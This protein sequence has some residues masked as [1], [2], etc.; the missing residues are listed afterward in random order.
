MAEICET[1][2]FTKWKTVYH[3]F[4]SLSERGWFQ[5][6]LKIPVEGRRAS[7]GL[8]DAI[9]DVDGIFLEYVKSNLGTP[10]FIPIEGGWVVERTFSWMDNYRR[11]TRNYEILLKVAAHMFIAACVFFMLRYFK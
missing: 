9:D 10:T 3:H 8:S 7:L 11:L 2:S 6:F 4:R 1:F 5:N